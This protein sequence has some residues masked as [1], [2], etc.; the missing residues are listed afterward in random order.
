M[1]GR[2]PLLHQAR[3]RAGARRAVHAG[4]GRA[5]PGP[6]RPDGHRPVRADHAGRL[7]A[8]QGGTAAGLPAVGGRRRGIAAAG[9][10]RGDRLGG[11]RAH[12][13]VPV[14]KRGLAAGREGVLLHAAAAARFGAC[15][16]K[17]VS[18]AGVPA[19]GRHARRA[20]RAHLRRGPGQDGLLR[21]LGQPGRALAVPV[22]LPGHGAAQRPVAGR[23]DV[24]RPRGT[25]AAGGA[26]GGGRADRGAGRAGRAAVPVHRPRRTAGADRGGR[27]G[28]GGQPGG[29][30]GPDPGGSRG[31]AGRVR[32]PGRCRAGPAG[33]G[34]VVGQAR[35]ERDHRAR[36]GVR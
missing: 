4:G 19:S 2:T 28:H 15:R 9:A 26:G 20:G 10:R 11:G 6:D 33:A 13:P 17:S 36:P 18:P 27:S 21:R 3:A 31:G 12:R 29:L 24:I 30:V 14:L 25:R 16:G 34:G 5:G 8:G 7:A 23:P 1:A 22:R 35:A 32:D